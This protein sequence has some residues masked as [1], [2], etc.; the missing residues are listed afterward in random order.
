MI[1]GPA[2]V[3]GE[4]LTGGYISLRHVSGAYISGKLN[5][6]EIRSAPVAQ[7]PSRKPGFFY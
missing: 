3:L 1:S 2:K 6:V 5:R 4:E 7:S